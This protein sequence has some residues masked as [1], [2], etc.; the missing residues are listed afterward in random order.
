MSTIPVRTPIGGP[1][2]RS[3][4]F[5]GGEHYPLSKDWVKWFQVVNINAQATSLSFEGTR[6]DRIASFPAA[7]YPGGTTYFETDTGLSYIVVN[8]LWAYLAGTALATQA[9]LPTL[10]A[11]DAGAL[12]SVTDYGHLLRWSGSA[13]GW[14]PGEAGGGFVSSFLVAPSASGWHLC[15][16][17]SV[18]RL[19]SDGT[20]SAVT[21]PNY[22]TAAYLKLGITASVGPNAASGNTDSVSAGTPAG[23]NTA[24][25]FTGA[26]DTTG[27]ESATVAVQS[28]AGTTVAA[29]NHTHDVTPTGTVSA[30]VFTGT[31]L[32][33]HQHGP[34]TL[35]LDNTVLLA[36][37]RQ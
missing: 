30:P 29:Q 12:Y 2:I 14:G 18:N 19:N 6:A 11:T 10:G 23:S 3:P 20:V 13:W 32:A 37:Y 36:Y 9:T 16:G 8:N 22:T 31:A 15:D 34:G 35:E 1:P 5:Q 7:S 25:S 24:P 4:F 33:G 28:G 17:S 26:S 27:F 21:L